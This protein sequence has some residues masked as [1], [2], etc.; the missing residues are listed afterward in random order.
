[1]TGVMTRRLATRAPRPQAP[2]RPGVNPP[3]A[4]LC[5]RRNSPSHLRLGISSAPRCCSYLPP[6]FLSIGF[7]RPQLTDPAWKAVVVVV[8]KGMCDMRGA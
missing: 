6:A 1:M 3:P 7:C 5:F 2:K 8:A 4:P